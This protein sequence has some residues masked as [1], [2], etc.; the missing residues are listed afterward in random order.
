MAKRSNGNTGWTLSGLAW[1]TAI[2]LAL[3]TL[4]I[5]PA[6]APITNL[7]YDNVSGAQT[8]NGGNGEG[9]GGGKQADSANALLSQVSTQLVE[10]ALDDSAFLIIRTANADDKDVEVVKWLGE[11]AG[12][13]NAGEIEL[14]DKF[15]DSGASDELRSVAAATLPAGAQLSKEN[16][17]PGFHAGELL[18][19]A[20]MLDPLSKEPIATV[21]DRALVLQTLRDKGYINYED[22][23][24]KPANG[25]IV[26]TGDNPGADKSGKK[27]DFGSVITAD[28]AWGIQDAGDVVVLA[29]RAGSAVEKGPLGIIRS[30]DTA[31]K[32]VSTVDS[33]DSETGRISTI[34]ALAE[35]L[36]GGAGAYGSADNAEA[37][38]PEKPRR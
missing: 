15:L 37:P 5:A 12:G 3:G 16:Q 20:L 28:F 11:Q 10:G 32:D 35:Q 14:T 4:V 22:G 31:K 30:N 27:D 17:A 36:R 9:T 6:M 21:E 7:G 29:G 19:A 23:T 1:G 24:I 26:V 18:G 8:S 33:I 34:I 13:F 2:G 38:A 25:I